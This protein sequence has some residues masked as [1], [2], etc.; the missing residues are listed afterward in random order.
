[1]SEL[2]LL[3]PWHRNEMPDTICR[4]LEFKWVQHQEGH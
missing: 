3:T 1:M 4:R 2:K